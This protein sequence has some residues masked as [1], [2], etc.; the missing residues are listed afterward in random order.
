MDIFGEPL[1]RMLQLSCSFL[2][3]NYLYVS[4]KI[5]ICNTFKMKRKKMEQGEK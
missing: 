3:I 5:K 2:L 1:F 4:K